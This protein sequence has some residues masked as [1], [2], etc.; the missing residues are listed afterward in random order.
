MKVRNGFV[1]NSSSSSFVLCE[2]VED[3]AEVRENN[4]KILDDDYGWGDDD[5][6][7][8]MKE[9]LDTLKGKKIIST[10]SIKYNQDPEDIESLAQAVA[11][12]YN[13]EARIEMIS[14]ID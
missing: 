8:M 12:H 10:I 6:E 2:V 5:C 14:I 9:A 3:S 4:F 7:D 11:S 13:P 1:S